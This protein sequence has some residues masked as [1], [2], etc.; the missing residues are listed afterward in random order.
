MFSETSFK[1]LACGLLVVILFVTGYEVA[2]DKYKAEQAKMQ[3][4]AV[5]EYAKALEKK[6]EV[7]SNMANSIVKS[8]SDLASDIER[9]TANYNSLISTDLFVPNSDWVQSNSATADQDG[10]MPDNS[11]AT[12]PVQTAPCK[13]PKSDGTKLQ[14]L[15]KQQLTVA[16][17]CDITTGYYNAVLKLYENLHKAQK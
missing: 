16:K 2:S 8:Q 7:Q 14:R 9:T 3:E 15:Y 12:E 11:T 4:K 6:N 10:S 5:Q 17:D 13:C 1:V